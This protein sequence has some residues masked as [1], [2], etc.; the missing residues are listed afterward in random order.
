MKVEPAKKDRPRFNPTA[1]EVALNTTAY[2]AAIVAIAAVSTT[3]TITLIIATAWAIATF[4]P[5]MAIGSVTWTIKTAI[6]RPF[7]TSLHHHVVATPIYP[8]SGLDRAVR[9]TLGQ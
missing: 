5:A 2:A 1:R 9:R 4:I 8:L 3:L 7:A 6:P